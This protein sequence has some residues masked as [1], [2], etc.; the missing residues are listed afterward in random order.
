MIIVKSI[1]RLGRNYDEMIE[2]WRI[3]TK[4]K[5]VDIKVVDMALLDTTY[6]KGLLGTFIADLT[7]QVLSL[8]AELERDGI[9]LRQAEGIA[10]AKARGVVFGRAAIKAPKGI[11]E[12]AVRWQAKALSLEDGAVKY[13]LSRSTVYRLFK[14]ALE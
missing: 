9:R 7:L 3:I 11:R 1:D 5:G 10:A 12:D 2:Q 4:D 14:Q 8:T 13:N 6:G